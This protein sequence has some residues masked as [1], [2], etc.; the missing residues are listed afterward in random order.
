LRKVSSAEVLA[1]TIDR[2]AATFETRLLVARLLD[3]C[4]RHRDAIRVLSESAADAPPVVAGQL[5]ALKADA[6]ADEVLR[7][8]RR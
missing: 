4:K 1:W 5:R 6:D 2:R 8:A 3:L 7:L